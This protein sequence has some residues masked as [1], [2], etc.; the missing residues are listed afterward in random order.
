MVYRVFC[1]FFVFIAG[2]ASAQVINTTTMDTTETTTIGH[3]GLGGYVDSYYGYNFNKPE[4]STNQ[5]FVS[6]ARDNEISINL[7]YVDVR[8]RSTYM[9]MRFVPGFGTYM[10]AN[11]KNEPGSLKNMLEAS[12]GVLV[13]PNKNIWIDAGVIGSPY[14]N[15]SA[16]SKDHLM[17]T[18]SFAPENVPYYLSGVKVSVPLSAK[19]NAY[20]YIINGWQVIQDNN[21]GKSVGT[22]LEFRPNGSMLFNWN[23][24]TGDERSTDNPNYRI[25]FFNDF[26]WIYKP[27]GR[28]SATSCFYFGYQQ[29]SDA[30]TA[31]WWQVNFIGS[32]KFNEIISLSGRIEHF[33]DPGVLYGNVNSGTGMPGFK[34]SSTGLCANFKLHKLALFRLEA[35][36]FF[37]T[38][39]V[40]EDINQN[41][42]SQSFLMMANLTAWF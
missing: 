5:Y 10:D 8:Y 27:K 39:N 15:E 33:N 20:L 40:Y 9:R 21:R 26:Y 35:R 25:R 28:F 14:T 38:E 1:L 2:M 11:Y 17:Y 13:F 31:S 42:T 4:N 7:A 23:T 37:S 12:V 24:Y 16:I 18:R 36:E 32:Y 6:S 3:V 34:S 30:P 41:P 19:L 29:K 22:Q